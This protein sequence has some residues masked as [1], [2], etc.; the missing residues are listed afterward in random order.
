I[1]KDF[2][3]ELLAIQ[4]SIITQNLF[5]EFSF[6]LAETFRIGKHNEARQLVRI[7]H[8]NSAL[9]K[10]AGHSAFSASNASRE[11]EDSARLMPSH[12]FQDLSRA[13]VPLETK[14][15]LET[16]RHAIKRAF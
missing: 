11:G 8:R 10:Q 14:Q 4:S 7:N 13:T 15:M 16:K 2:L 3:T 1:R 6:D 5:S 12:P 9:F